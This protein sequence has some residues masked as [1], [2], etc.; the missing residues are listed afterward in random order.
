MKTLHSIPYEKEINNGYARLQGRNGN[1]FLNGIQVG[2]VDFTLN[3]TVWG[4]INR[5]YFTPIRNIYF[6]LETTGT[7]TTNTFNYFYDA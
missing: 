4:N 6:T 5:D 7:T 1:I 3:N 2:N